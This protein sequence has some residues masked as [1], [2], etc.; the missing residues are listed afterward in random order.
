MEKSTSTKKPWYK[1]K[2]VMIPLVIVLLLI[3]CRIYLPYYVKD[4]LN[5]T[6]ANIPGYYGHID[7]VGISLYRGAYQL[8]DLYLDKKDSKTQT[9]FLDFPKTDISIQWRALINGRVV[10]EIT[11]VEPTII[12]TFEDHVAADGTLEEPSVEVWYSVLTDIIPLD[13][14]KFETIDGTF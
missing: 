10:S 11:M 13:I 2:K 8:N 5:K 1:R 3:G 6:L 12:Y 7:D 4:Q 9:P 14:N